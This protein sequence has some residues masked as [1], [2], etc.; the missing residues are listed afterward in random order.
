MTTWA[1]VPVK[2]FQTGKSRLGDILC[3]EDRRQ[4]NCY[5]LQRT[6][7]ILADVGGLDKILVISSDE[8]VLEAAREAGAN[9][10]LETGKRGLNRALYQATN[11]LDKQN[12]RVVIIPTDL[13]L[14]TADDVEELLSTG[15]IPPVV[16][17]VPD[18]C[19]NGTNAL[20]I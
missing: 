2:P 7:S 18:R 11:T 4:L 3:D 6:L 16:V 9:V 19:G 15:A 12:D 14:M 1:I 10:L 17:I 20:L 8:Q 5:L 13:P